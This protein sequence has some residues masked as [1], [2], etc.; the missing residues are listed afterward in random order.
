MYL[1]YVGDQFIHDAY[2]DDR[3]VHDCKL[4]GDVNTFLTLEFTVPPTNP[5]AKSLTKRDYAHPVVAT[6]DDQRLFRGYIE[7]TEEQLDTEVKVTCKGDLAMLNDSVVRPYTTKQGDTSGGMQYIGHGYETLF[8]WLINRHNANVVY[9]GADGHTHGTEKQ[10]QIRYPSGSG[11]SLA[12]ECAV[13]DKRSGERPYSQSKP[14]TLGEI[15]GKITK[16]L[17][18]Y[19]QL[20]Y[21]GD[22]KCLALYAD[23]PDVLK[24]NQVVQFGRNMTDYMFEDSCVD[25]YTAIRAQGGN[26][27]NSNPVTFN[28]IADGVKSSAYYKRGDVVYHMANAAK[29]GYR[30]YAWSNSDITDANALL[31]NAIVQLKKI[32]T[33]A[34]SIDVSAMDMVFV[35][36]DYR[37]LL[38]G[39]LVTVQ[40]RVHNVDTELL[41]S[42]CN[43]DFDSP[44]ATK[45]TMGSPLAK[46]T[47]TY[48]S[49]IEDITGAADTT[50]DARR[51]A[52]NA[53]DAAAAAQ[54]TALQATAVSIKSQGQTAISRAADDVEDFFTPVEGITATGSL[55]ST[56]SIRQLSLEI[57]LSSM[58]QSG[59]EIGTIQDIPAIDTPLSGDIIGYI[60]TNGAI[61]IDQDVK[62]SSKYMISAV[63]VI[64]ATNV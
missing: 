35:D 47:K 61:I 38:P 46:I 43:I 11:T 27:A 31:G 45:F 1:V 21:D 34:Q 28:S 7:A 22:V 23:V 36:T 30:E 64:G 5:M 6:F 39:Q 40:S 55:V 3:K 10:F 2:S 41:V 60:S 44:S 17:G 49:I 58:V 33:P 12:K 9:I 19:L 20:W 24:N 29:Y 57:T 14:T 15:Q 25:T 51:A 48:G 63:F 18:A 4:S 32:M 42:S 37:H 50:A 16:A 26:D 54:Q 52:G 62:A 59:D 13:L 53:Y 56:G 8:K